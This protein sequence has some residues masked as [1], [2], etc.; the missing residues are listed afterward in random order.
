V[1]RAQVAGDQ[2]VLEVADDGRGIRW[3][4]VAEQAARSGLPHES[5]GDLEQALFAPGL[6]TSGTVTEISGRG[7]GLS[8]VADRCRELGGH[9]RLESAPGRGTRF[10]FS[11]PRSL[12]PP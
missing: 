5:R 2:I 12:P 8:A 11:F 6:S 7:V 10:V 3:D 1:L 4:R 9:W